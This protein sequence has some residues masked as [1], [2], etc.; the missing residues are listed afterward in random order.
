MLDQAGTAPEIESG[1]HQHDLG[2]RA[3]AK[4]RSLADAQPGGLIRAGSNG[5]TGRNQ[6][7]GAGCHPDLLA[8]GQDERRAAW[9]ENHGAIDENA[10]EGRF[11]IGGRG[12]G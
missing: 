1:G 7:A 8:I 12:A 4:V 2:Q 11:P 9:L 10:L 3:H 5:R 6:T